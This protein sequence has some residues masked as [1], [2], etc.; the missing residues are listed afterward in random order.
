MLSYL[1]TFGLFDTYLFLSWFYIV[2]IGI[3]D[4]YED[5]PVYLKTAFV[6]LF[7]AVCALIF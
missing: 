6:L 1:Q 4:M 3:T 5:D 7:G 2:F